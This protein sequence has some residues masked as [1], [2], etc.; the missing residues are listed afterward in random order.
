MRLLKGAT[1]YRNQL[2]GQRG[3]KSLKL[4]KSL[5][6]WKLHRLPG[7]KIGSHQQKRVADNHV[8]MT[9]A[10]HKFFRSGVWNNRG[11]SMCFCSSELLP[12]Q[13]SNGKITHKLMI[14]G[15]QFLKFRCQRT[16]GFLCPFRV[17]V[18][19]ERLSMSQQ[20]SPTTQLGLSTCTRAPIQR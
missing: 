9:T 10:S 17:S 3:T 11:K 14:F 13:R 18:M 15:G 19:F 8:V 2:A 5:V 1:A 16:K 4:T 20:R 7:D 6:S 12:V